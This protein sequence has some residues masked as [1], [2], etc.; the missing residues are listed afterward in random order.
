MALKSPGDLFLQAGRLKVV[1][2]LAVVGSFFGVN[3]DSKLVFKGVIN[4]HVFVDM[5]HLFMEQ[6]A[7]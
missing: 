1:N 2:S 7:Y 4:V 5:G 6:C 3:M